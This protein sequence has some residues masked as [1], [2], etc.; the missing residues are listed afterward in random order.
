MSTRLLTKT[1]TAPATRHHATVR[2]PEATRMDLE[3]VAPVKP[4][5]AYIGGKKVLARTI[6]E[7]INQIQH[8]SYAEP[9]VGMGGVFFRRDQKSRTEII[10]DLSGDIANLFRILQR[11]YVQFMEVLKFQLT[12]RREFERLVA[13]NADTLT[14]L[15]RAAR[16]LYLQKT[17]F[18]GKVV[19]R[20][21]GVKPGGYGASFNINKLGPVLEDIH[22]RLA[23]VVIECLPYQEFIAR[24][25]RPS[26]LF[27]LD[28][29]YWGTES[30]YGKDLFSRA[31]FSALAE[32]L[33]TIKGQF[34]LS[35][36]D[37]PQVR[38]LFGQFRISPVRVS[39]SIS[40]KQQKQTGE[41]IISNCLP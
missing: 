24:Y 5:A 33:G 20:A 4:A 41:L 1:D 16:F 26:T 18:G 34:V 28:P 14:D 32:Q 9:F 13:M 12:S 3:P 25:D 8:Q 35:L 36:N 30:Y 40:E 11:H 15:E 6:I 29:P 27:Y 37:V 38:E 19:N 23:R 2:V 17:A 10:N 21:F 31:D 7:R 39:Y 22:E